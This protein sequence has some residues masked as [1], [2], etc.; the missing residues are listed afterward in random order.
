MTEVH[1]LQA[2]LE[3]L[4]EE[5][6]LSLVIAALVAICDDY[7]VDDPNNG[8]AWD[9]MARALANVGRNCDL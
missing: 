4:I 8:D 2:L 1:E 3:P 5:H 7:R 9:R 6:S